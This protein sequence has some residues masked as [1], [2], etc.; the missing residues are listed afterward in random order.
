MSSFT[1]CYTSPFLSMFTLL[2]AIVH[3]HAMIRRG[4]NDEALAQDCDNLY[5]KNLTQPIVQLIYFIADRTGT[6]AYLDE[7]ERT[8][9]NDTN[10]DV[11]SLSEELAVFA[12]LAVLIVI[13]FILIIC[14]SINGT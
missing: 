7:T 6:R 9:L 14:M 13:V 5:D 10:T 2:L 1:A 11:A 3:C 12:V 4:L 8:L